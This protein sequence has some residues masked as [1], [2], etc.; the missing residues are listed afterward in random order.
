MRTTAVTRRFLVAAVAGVLLGALLVAAPAGAATSG[1]GLYLTGAGNGHGIGMSQYGAAGY[2]LARRQDYQD[3]LRD[4]Y[5]RTTLGHVS[6]A[7]P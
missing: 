5:T 2:A 6:P 7:G 3:I 4:Y 1:S